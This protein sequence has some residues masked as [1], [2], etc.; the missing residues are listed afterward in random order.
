MEKA[1]PAQ[2][3]PGSNTSINPAEESRKKQYKPKEANQ[4]P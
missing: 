4:A 1:E 3:H 2:K